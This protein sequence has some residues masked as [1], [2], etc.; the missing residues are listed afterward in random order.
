MYIKTKPTTDDKSDTS[1]F[2]FDTHNINVYDKL[3]CVMQ[4]CICFVLFEL[5]WLS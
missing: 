2:D 5:S 4:V 1:E 3:Y